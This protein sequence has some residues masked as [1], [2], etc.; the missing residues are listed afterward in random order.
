M[1]QLPIL[2]ARLRAA[3]NLAKMQYAVHNIKPPFRRLSRP[4]SGFQLA[5]QLLWA[6]LGLI[7][8]VQLMTVVAAIIY[9][10][11]ILFIQLF[12][13]Y[14]EEDPNRVDKSRG[15][16][17]VVGIFIAHVALVLGEDFVSFPLSSM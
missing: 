14:L 5:Y 13:A 6:N 9:Y 12:L 2:P 7:A 10:A 15:W 4:G 16:F 8:G 3:V 1:D 11:P 17:Y